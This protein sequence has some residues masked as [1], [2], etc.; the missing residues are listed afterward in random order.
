MG[1]LPMK[2]DEVHPINVY[3]P[4]AA[5]NG[6][7]IT[8][9]K[10]IYDM[11]V[12]GH[13]MGK[14]NTELAADYDYTTVTITN[15]LR[16]DQAQIMIKNAHDTIRANLNVKVEESVDIQT[17]IRQRALE[18]A[19]EFLN[20]DEAAKNSPFAYMNTIKSLTG[21]SAPSVNAPTSVNVN[22]QNNN[23]ISKEHFDRLSTA[24]E[25]SSK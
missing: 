17:R 7:R 20:N 18:R 19:E 9:W 10:P 1:N 12:A 3:R 11:I 14:K 5:P 23:N 25:I 15:I 4:P 6:F 16:S 8:R 22:V 13:I 21:L 2:R 24:L